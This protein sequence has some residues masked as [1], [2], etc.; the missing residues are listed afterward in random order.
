MKTLHRIGLA[1]P[2]I[3]LTGLV[4][5]I[6]LIGANG[7]WSEYTDGERA[8]TA[9]L[10]L[11]TGGSV[12][13]SLSIAVDRRVDSVPWLRITAIVVLLLLSFGAALVRRNLILDGL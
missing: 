5:G 4:F 11:L 8:L 13:L 2:L 10:C 1:T 7:L 3:G 12:A 9:L 6:S